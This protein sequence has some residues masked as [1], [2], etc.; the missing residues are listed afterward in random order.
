M[1]CIEFKMD[2]ISSEE[3]LYWQRRNSD[4]ICEAL[5]RLCGKK[6]SKHPIIIRKQECYAGETGKYYVSLDDCHDITNVYD[7]NQKIYNIP[8]VKVLLDEREICFRT[9]QE[10]KT[11]LSQIE[12]EIFHLGN[13]RHL[14][15]VIEKLFSE[16]V[17][18]IPKLR[19]TIEKN[20]ER[21]KKIKK[22]LTNVF[23]N[24]LGKHD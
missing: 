21:I 24:F 19:E 8:E 11:T 20:Q 4:F 1:N 13:V 5:E 12:K 15:K 16:K 18:Q 14:D 3:V 17:E 10:T 9:V 23:A 6:F 2:C 22:E 7:A